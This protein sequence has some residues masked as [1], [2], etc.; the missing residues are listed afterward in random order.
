MILPDPIAAYFDADTNADEDAIT[1]CFADDAVV[2]DEGARHI[3]PAAIGAWWRA[4]KRRY[5]HFIEPLDVAEQDGLVVVRCKVS[6]NFPGSPITLP[7]AF[8]LAGDRIRSLAI[9]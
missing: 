1:Q 5:S 3:G 4:A 8:S 7:F 6:G 9:G 2:E